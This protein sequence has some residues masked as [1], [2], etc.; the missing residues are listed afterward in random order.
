MAPPRLRTIIWG[1]PP[2][3]RKLAHKFFLLF[4]PFIFGV[5]STSTAPKPAQ[6]RLRAPSPSFTRNSAIFHYLT[7]PVQLPDEL[8]HTL[9]HTRYAKQKASCLAHLR[10]PLRHP[11][12][13]QPLLLVLSTSTISFALETRYVQIRLFRLLFVFKH[14]RNQ[15]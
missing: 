14:A 9:P 8:V 13:P 10:R 6:H 15:E 4:S 11:R 3:P 1:T 5:F 7:Q 2:L 12:S